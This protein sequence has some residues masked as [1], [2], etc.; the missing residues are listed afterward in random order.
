MKNLYKLAQKFSFKLARK[1]S[2]FSAFQRGDLISYR[3]EI[4]RVLNSNEKFSEV[5][6]TFRTGFR[7]VPTKDLEYLGT[8]QELKELLKKDDLLQSPIKENYSPFSDDQE[9]F[10][11]KKETKF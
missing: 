7:K 4:G 8:V 1:K 3:G 2:N 9:Y 6:F 11:F 5:D 10:S